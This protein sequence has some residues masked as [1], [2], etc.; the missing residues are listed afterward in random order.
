MPKTYTIEPLDRENYDTWTIQAEAILIKNKLWKY[1][2][3]PLAHDASAEDV[4]GDRQAKAELILIISPSQLKEI[5]NCTS[6]KAL[7]DKLKSIY[8]SKGPARKASLL[9]QL[10]MT[11]LEGNDVRAHLNTFMDIVDKLADMEI[12]INE[13]LLTIMMLYSLSSDYENFRVAIESRDNLP[14][15]EELK[16]KI[17][18]ESNA[19]NHTHASSETFHEEDN[20]LYATCKVCKKKGNKIFQKKTHKICSTCWK[21]N[22]V[23]RT[24]T[25]DPETTNFADECLLTSNKSND[26]NRDWVLDSGC[27]SHMSYQSEFFS[28]MK[29]VSRKLNF[30]S[31]DHYTEIKGKGTVI[32]INKCRKI[33]LEETLYVP[34]LSTNLL[35]VPKMTE[36]GATVTFGNNEASVRNKHGDVILTAQK[37]KINGL[38]YI[39]TPNIER[40]CAATTVTLD[41]KQGTIQD[42]HRKLGHM[43]DKDLH[44]ALNNETLIGLKFNKNENLS[45]CEACIQAKMT[46]VPSP[47]PRSTPRTTDRLEIVHSDVCGPIKTPSCGNNKYFVTFIDDY[48]RYGRVYFLKNKTEVLDKFKDYK[49]E[50]EKFTGNNIKF[51]Q[52]DNGTEYINGKFEAYLK[53]NGIARRLSAPYT[54]HQNGIAERKNRTLVEKAR[55]MLIDAKAPMHLW[56]EAV[57]TA[58]YLSNRSVNSAIEHMTPYEKWVGRKPC[59]HHLH[60]FGSKAF[61]LIKGYRGHKFAPK[62]I[63]GIFIG[64]SDIS[65]AFRIYVPSKR[66]T[67][68]SKDVRIVKANY[69]TNTAIG[70]VNLK[71]DENKIH[72][73]SISQKSQIEIETDTEENT[74]QN[75]EHIVEVPDSTQQV[76]NVCNDDEY[77]TTSQHSSEP[78]QEPE[79]EQNGYNLRDRSAIHPPQRYDDFV[80]AAVTEV[81]NLIKEPENYK[82]AINSSNKEKWLE[83]MLSEV[84]S[85]KENQTWDL[86]N[87]PKGR[88]ALPCKWVFKI[89]TNP[90]GSVDKFKARLV[91]KGYS[92]QQGVD[93]DMTFSPV[94]RLST[95]RAV[96]AIAAK[97]NMNL[98]QFD[99]TTAFLNGSVDEEIYVKQP[100]GFQDGTN[101]VCKL[102]RSLYGLKQAPRCW[103]SCIVEFLK[104]IGFKQSEADPCLFTRT[105]GQSKVIIGLYVDDGLVASN[106]SAAGN[107][108]IMELSNRFKITTKPAS[109]FLGI[110]IKSEIGRITL[111]QQAYTKKV[112]EKFGMANSKPTPT[113]IVKECIND[114]ELNS[115]RDVIFPY[116]QA[117]GA[118]TYLAVG[119]RPDIAYAVG[120]A[121]RNLETPT[122]NDVILV[123]RILRYLKG[124]ADKGLV[125]RHTMEIPKG[126]VCYSDSD[127]GGDPETGRSTSGMVCLLSGAAISWRSHRQTMVS[128]SSTEAEIIAASETAQEL[129]WLNSLLK[130][131]AELQKPVLYLDNESAIKLSHNPKYEFHKR[132]KHIKL[133]HLFVRE[134][135]TNGELEVKQVPSSRQLADMLTKPLYG[136]RLEDLSGRIGLK[137]INS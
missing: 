14:K 31:E 33:R 26:C 101:R 137:R 72:S 29:T 78:E 117:V 53:E 114:T 61:L 99:V 58:N 111:C 81:E 124:T 109:Y 32:F 79:N 46:C 3:T 92:Q 52:T 34:S 110:E 38:Y 5:K 18:E 103:N 64:Y 27:T 7:W 8:A 116:R 123:K 130:D 62:A 39:K 89:K 2:E 77:E 122:T 6:S 36:H 13:D 35:S 106:T 87:L 128:I 134:C 30:A 67:M 136:P 86:I 88:R 98:R 104:S 90:D 60:P 11:K 115:E 45:D 10:I 135:V 43:N 85:L 80:L 127:L 82:E 49:K 21:K 54:P 75:T 55:A 19:R 24:T 76:E 96:L 12:I 83:A 40:S 1:I 22:K 17:I 48:S 20:A 69:Y 84:N 47:K 129:V 73:D 131:L 57:N 132:T 97:D 93:Y 113:P 42:W 102:K 41:N 37:S 9:K 28:D 121:S 23:K 74:E 112:V 63:P 51:L 25:D 95:I 50:V 68:V 44:L 16:I 15:P 105:R 66:K 56:G 107:E 108:F 120:K 71:Y 94:A 126:L 125:Y 70:D 65:K 118:L 100:E 91:V 133:K 119:T 4:E 59:V